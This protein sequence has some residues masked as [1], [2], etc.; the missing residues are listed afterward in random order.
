MNSFPSQTNRVQQNVNGLQQPQTNHQPTLNNKKPGKFNKF[1]GSKISFVVLVVIITILLL[2]AIAGIVVASNSY[3]AGSMQAQINKNEYQAVFLNNADGQVYFGKLQ[4]LNKNYYK[5]SDIY[6]VK[7]DKSIQ[8]G[9]KDPQSNISLAKLGAEIHA[10][11]DVMYINKTTVL[12]WENLK[13]SGQVVKAII[14][15][16]KN[17]TPANTQQTPNNSTNKQ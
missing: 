7:V 13:P 5:L 16:Q 17:P 9:Q 12:F 3:N 10:P 14:E 2:A 11:E 15:Y 4:D 8:P 6:Y 1:N